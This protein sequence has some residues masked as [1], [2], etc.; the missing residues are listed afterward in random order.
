LT[1]KF[2]KVWQWPG[3]GVVWRRGATGPRGAKKLAVP[4][5]NVLTSQNALIT[6]IASVSAISEMLEMTRNEV[7]LARTR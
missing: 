3:G 4:R 7:A 2:V 6:L 1:E 5:M